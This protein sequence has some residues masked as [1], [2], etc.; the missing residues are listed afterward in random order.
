VKTETPAFIVLPE[1]R[2]TALSIQYLVQ[3]SG[4]ALAPFLAGLLAVKTS[5]GQA[6]IIVPLHGLLPPF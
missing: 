2:S 1:V 3:N 4:A 5:L 6:I